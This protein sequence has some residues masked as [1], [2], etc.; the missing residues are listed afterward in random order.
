[1]KKISTIIFVLLSVLSKQAIA[2]TPQFGNGYVNISKK[3][4]GGKVEKDDILEIRMSIHLPWGYNGGANGRIYR[5]RYVDNI[6]TNTQMLTSSSD[7]IRILTNEG[8][9]YKR[10]TLNGGDD[11]ASYN[12]SPSPGQY[13]IRINMGR[14]P[15]APLNNNP[16]TV[17]GSDSINLTN[18]YPYGSAP[19]WWTG[20]IFST[21]YR[22]RVTGNA[23]DS[24]ML[25]PAQFI[26][27]RTQNGADT[28]I[29][30]FPYKILIS[31]K[32][33]LC[34]NGLA[35]NL[36]GESNGT[37]GT[38]NTLNRGTGPSILVPNYI[39][40]NNVSATQDVS[41]GSY[42]IV[43]NLSPRASTNRNARRV[44]N[45]TAAPA[46]PA[47]DSCHNRM[48]DGSWFIDGD[49]SG[50]NN[51]AGNL[52]VAA[53]TNGG[54]MLMVNADYITTEA[55]RQTI[56]GLCP[57]SFYEFSA[58]VKNIC[59]LCGG[60]SLLN[61]TY[62]PGVLPNL[63][64]EINDKDIYSTGE[65]D[66]VGWVRKGFLFR[67]GASQTSATFSIRNNAQGG[68]GNDWA[69]DDIRLSACV[70]S[71][72]MN[73]TP[74]VLGCSNVPNVDV[75]LICRVRYAYNGSY[76]YYKWQRSTNNGVSWTDIF[77]GGPAAPTY[78]SGAWEYST[79][80]HFLANGSDSG[81]RFRVVVATTAGNLSSSTC[82]FTDGN[83]TYL[84]FLPCGSNLVTNLLSFT[85]E[86]NGSIAS[87]N[88][89]VASETDLSHYEVEK[90]T[91]GQLFTKITKV[92]ALAQA[93][94][95]RYRFTDPDI[96]NGAAYYRL[97][98]VNTD[99]TFQYSKVVM[100]STRGYSF[101]VKPVMNPFSGSRLP[102]DYIM[103]KDGTVTVQ[104][105]DAAGKSLYHREYPSIKGSNSIVLNLPPAL[106]EGFY[107]IRL[108]CEGNP[109][110]I[111]KRLIKSK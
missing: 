30:A 110:A 6:P 11:A 77:T 22:V 70:P 97:K 7:S 63:T 31:A 9:T 42:A 103:P 95:M 50:T 16:N 102:V 3:A 32:D 99:G 38:G 73:Y 91:D 17:N 14:N 107:I 57:N 4:T 60:D 86:L 84:R 35:I 78:I 44:P 33:T 59:P 56:T 104:L 111:S 66:T 51:A 1:M 45:C 53:G 82:A 108:Q 48:F 49:H 29:T 69:L 101:F 43:N 26:F 34:Q 12:N 75:N 2:Q 105:F 96:I 76:L 106:A 79:N 36:A 10:Y 90:S 100:L 46:V 54:Y 85:G 52:P 15:T 87:L 24:V 47:A 28:F 5:V 13:N 37:F 61:R 93:G 62:R 40:R 80:Y 41:D 55:Y 23:G 64:F 74:F 92:P 88:W 25:Q 39:Y 81:H 89:R 8:L 94:E 71:T 72:S 67:T 19:K 27:R 68:G 18:V 83:F 98:M 21:S 109:V 65:I 20:H 58:W